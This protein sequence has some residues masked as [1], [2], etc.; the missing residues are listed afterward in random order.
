[1]CQ[2]RRVADTFANETDADA[3]IAELEKAGYRAIQTSWRNYVNIGMPIG[4]EPGDVDWEFD[5]VKYVVNEHG[6]AIETHWTS[7]QLHS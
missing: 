7:H 2:W 1:M 6:H 4:W 3:K 5:H